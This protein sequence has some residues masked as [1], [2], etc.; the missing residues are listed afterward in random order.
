MLGVFDMDKRYKNSEKTVFNIE[1]RNVSLDS[2]LISKYEEN[3][4][5][6]SEKLLSSL[7]YTFGQN[8]TDQILSYRIELDMA[9]E[10]EEYAV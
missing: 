1:N 3:I 8:C 7:I 6:L 5:P 9:N 10:L 4:C 2:A